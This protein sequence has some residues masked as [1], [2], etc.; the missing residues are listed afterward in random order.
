MQDRVPTKP[1]RYAVYDDAHNF[2]R[3]E[4]HE[5]ADEPTQVGDALNKANLLPD[6]VATAL[7]LT[8]NVQVKDALN[9]IK[10]LADTAQTTANGRVQIATGSY[11]GTGTYGASN[12]SSL[13]FGFAPK[14]IFLMCFTDI[15]IC[16]TSKLTTDY[17][18][19]GYQ[20]L[21]RTASGEYAKLSA[22]GK[23]LYWYS[24]AG[25]AYQLNQGSGYPTYYVAI[26]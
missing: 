4:Y 26:G 19:Y 8:G 22:D 16:F 11:T 3:H 7:G 5:R 10:A 14:L 9:K 13:S 12:P 15:A 1:N 21:T 6:A 17:A 2:L 20:L 25:A 23:T 24:T 18:Q